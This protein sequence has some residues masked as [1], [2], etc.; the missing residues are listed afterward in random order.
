MSI[1]NKLQIISKSEPENWDYYGEREREK[2]R[3]ERD[4]RER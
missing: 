1:F 3:G 2:A 4:G